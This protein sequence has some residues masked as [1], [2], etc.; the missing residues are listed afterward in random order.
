MS[1]SLSVSIVTYRP[2]ASVIAE[3][4]QTLYAA[5]ARALAQGDLEQASVTI[6]DN[7]P[8]TQYA[9]FLEE[10]LQREFAGSSVRTEL[11][12]GHGNIGYG[13]GHNFALLSSQCDFHL[14]L[15]PDV[16]LAADAITAALT[17]MAANPDVAMLAPLAVDLSGER[18]FLC[19]RYPSVLDLLLRGFAPGF[20]KRLFSSRLGRY[21]MRDLPGDRPSKRVPILSG[22][23]MFC[24][25]ALVAGVGGFSD[26]FFLYFEDF[27]LSL[28]A[29]RCGDLAWVPTV[30]IVH[31][32]GQAARKGFRHVLFFARSAVAFFNR[33]GWKWA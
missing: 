26:A 22:S 1:A 20:V 2:D 28:R 14:V 17:F 21:E 32:G 9:P 5:L 27:D 13:R 10:Q 6:V 7:G 3:T 24:R 8:G 33:H 16:A 15:N 23:F 18:L 12:S 30:R 11:L 19:K 29:A 25:R 31:R 4:L